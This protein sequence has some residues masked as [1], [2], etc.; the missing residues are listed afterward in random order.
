MCGV[1]VYRVIHKQTPANGPNVKRSIF[2][3]LH[4]MAE[5]ICEADTLRRFAEM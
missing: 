4:L 2:I 1:Y 5:A 3:V